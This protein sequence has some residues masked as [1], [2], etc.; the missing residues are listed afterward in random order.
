[1]LSYGQAKIVRHKKPYA[2]DED[3]FMGVNN[4]FYYT[5]IIKETE[6]KNNERITSWGVVLE[7]R[8]NGFILNH[9]VLL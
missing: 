7:N 6:I 1:M 8:K 9:S 4:I 2:K 3:A 5:V